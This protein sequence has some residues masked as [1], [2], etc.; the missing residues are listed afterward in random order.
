[1][2]TYTF[3]VVIEPDDDRWHAY[4]PALAEYGGATWGETREDALANLEAVVKMV[5]A[6]LV[7]HGEPI[8]P[9]APKGSV[10]VLAEPLLA[11]TV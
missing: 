6:S 5:V 7:E 10:E 4:C 11:V 8:A 2:T 9:A 3:K 1:M